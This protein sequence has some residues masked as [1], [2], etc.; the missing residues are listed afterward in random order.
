MKYIFSLA[1]VGIAIS[2]SC[3][4]SDS[5]DQQKKSNPKTSTV[6][7]RPLPN[8]LQKSYEALVVKL[9][10]GDISF[11]TFHSELQALLAPFKRKKPSKNLPIFSARNGGAWTY[12][13][14][15]C[16]FE[17]D[18][19]GCKEFWYTECISF[20]WG[21][22]FIYA[23]AASASEEAANADYFAAQQECINTT[24]AGAGR[25]SCMAAAEAVFVSTMASILADYDWANNQLYLCE[26]SCGSY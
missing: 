14:G 21:Q 22:Y 4:K 20:C 10:S 9:Q 16:D 23:D 6:S 17:N 26:T 7:S 24:N 3:N 5:L 1:L 12:T 13:P 2:F 25:D 15:P 19:D 18:P 11:G 8:Q